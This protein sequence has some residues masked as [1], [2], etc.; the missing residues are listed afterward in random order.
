MALLHVFF[1]DRSGILYRRDVRY[2]WQDF[3]CKRFLH[4]AF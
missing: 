4:V 2:E 1:R 3:V